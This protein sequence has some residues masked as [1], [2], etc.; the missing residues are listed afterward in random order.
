MPTK[1]RILL[2]G[3]DRAPLHE[4]AAEARREAPD[5]VVTVADSADS[6][7]DAL[8]SGPYDVVAGDLALLRRHWLAIASSDE[9]NA[10]LPLAYAAGVAQA[11]RMEAV[12][13]LAGGIAHDFNNLLTAILGT[14][15]LLLDEL[16][17]ED[18]HR[19][20]V[21]AICASSE[22]AAALTRQL[23]AFSRRQILEPAVIDVNALLASLERPL[24][25]LMSER[26]AVEL[27]L[28][29]DLPVVKV[30]SSQLSRALVN[31]AVNAR[32]A[33]PS[34]G[35]MVVS[36]SVAEVDADFAAGHPGLRPGRFV[37][38]A[39]SDSG[40]GIPPE[41]LPR[42]FEPFFTTK[43]IGRGTGLG[44]S[45]VYGIVKQSDGYIRVESP[46]G[47]GA[48]V[49]IYLPALEGAPASDREEGPADV[50]T[51]SGKETVLVV[52]DEAGVRDFM[53]RVLERRGYTVL[54]AA[55]SRDA[56]EIVHR[57]PG[58][59]DAV[60]TD[61]A[62]PGGEGPE[63]VDALGAIEPGLAVLYVSGHS[64]RMSEVVG[65]VGR[66]DGFLHKPF[67]PEVLLRSV[68]RILDDRRS[69]PAASPDVVNRHD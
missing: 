59:M 53:R 58:H 14:G 42:V 68:R 8:R 39:V 44:L 17:A 9:R 35:T 69:G 27:R 46:P 57:Y 65:P 7:S 19:S 63:L 20:D 22:R 16:P 52:E 40:A 21:E 2:A 25:D 37:C 33:M 54:T 3:L 55:N 34:G 36:T 47:S 5:S 1:T 18:P 62:M 45:A 4:L 12:G 61:V 13:E 50:R 30:D 28:S 29:P 32:D 48:T 10:P 49:I 67:S 60:V 24:I 23:L 11:Q 15:R 38:V 6:L 31:I 66:K 26:I 64:E 56:L 41:V 43:P 51:L